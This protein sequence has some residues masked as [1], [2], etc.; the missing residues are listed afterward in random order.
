MNFLFLGIESSG[1]YHASFCLL[2]V[3]VDF[4]IG[5]FSLEI[6]AP[7]SLRIRQPIFLG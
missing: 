1:F 4:G 2:A 3:L 6:Q 7:K 5:A